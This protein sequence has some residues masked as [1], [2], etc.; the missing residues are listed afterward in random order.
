MIRLAPAR[1]AVALLYMG[2]IVLLSAAHPFQLGSLGLS[3]RAL[4]LGHVPLFA[5]LAWVTFWALVG[6]RL[7]CAL[8]AAMICGLFALIDEW[9]Q[10]FV[11]GRVASLDDLAADGAGIV[12]GIAVAVLVSEG[13]RLGGAPANGDTS[14]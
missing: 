2:L 3:Q 9:H 10:N 13:W 11:P 1:V 14:G 8:G 5:G 6:P 7:Q 4:N 12:L